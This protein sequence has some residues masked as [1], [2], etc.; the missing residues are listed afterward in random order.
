[1]ARSQP[2][3]SGAIFPRYLGAIHLLIL[4]V[5][6]TAVPAA[7]AVGPVIALERISITSS[8]ASLN[9]DSFYA[10]ISADGRF[11]AFD[12]AATDLVPGARRPA[13][14]GDYPIN[15]Y[16]RDRTA[17]TLELVSIG[18]NGVA[19][20]SFSRSP[21]ISA[22][23]RYVGFSS[24]ASNLVSG[25]TNGLSDVFVRDRLL[26]TTARVSLPG[27]GPDTAGGG[28]TDNQVSSWMSANGRYVIFSSSAKLTANNSNLHRHI[29]RRDLVAN[30]TVLVDVNP[31]AVAADNDSGPGGSISADGRFVMFESGS[32]DILPDANP[33][34]TTHLYVRD[35][36]A[37]VTESLTPYLSLPGLCPFYTGQSGTYNLSGN[38]R[39]AMFESYCTDLAVGQD[40]LDHVFVRDLFLGITKPFRINDSGAPGGYALGSGAYPSIT[41]SGRHAVAWTQTTNIVAG[42]S[43]NYSDV[44][45]HDFAAARTFR[46]SQRADNGEAANGPSYSP[47]IAPGG[48]V[49]F[50]SDASNLVDGDDNGLRDIFVATL[51]AVFTGGFE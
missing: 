33:Y 17:G 23:G 38:G 43:D 35:M 49:L 39:F 10:A 8:G 46:I 45:L 12:S 1:M 41:N 51:D 22:D 7:H 2:H 47:L 14:A 27:D 9:N 11:V 37:G 48:R 26:G 31:G 24:T 34:L 18:L 20:N 44:F 50:A 32:N 13:S 40:P 30:T 19:P 5:A 16:L 29:Y 4:T 15:V 21:A 42:D 6:L 36:L 28:T 25:D 3:L